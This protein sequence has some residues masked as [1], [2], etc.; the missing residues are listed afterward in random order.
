MIKKSLIKIKYFLLKFKGV[1]I[2]NTTTI[3]KNVLFK[4]N[5]VNNNKGKIKIGH[6]CEL[7]TGVILN[8]YGGNIEIKNNVYLGEYVLIYGHGGITIGS[9]TL[10]AMHTCIV[11]SNHTIPSKSHLIRDN[12]DIL[13]PVLIGNDVWIGANCS[14]LGGV[15]IGDGAVIGAGSVVTK[16]IPAYAIAFGN[17]AKVIR[18][19]ND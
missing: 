13:L 16:N 3:N 12:S 15:N 18:Y 14:I 8:A 5:T 9:N 11:T 19:R 2:E 4:K 7:N 10:I 6:R 17:P 1:E